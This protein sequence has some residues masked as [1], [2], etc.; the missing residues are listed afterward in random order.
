MRILVAA[1]AT[2]VIGGVLYFAVIGFK[3]MFV[4][5]RRTRFTSH[6]QV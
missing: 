3:E 5:C 1:G 2:G 4:V 6:Q